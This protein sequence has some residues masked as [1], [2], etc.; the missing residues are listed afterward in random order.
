MDAPPEHRAGFVALAGL[1]NVGKSTLLNRLVGARLSIVTRKAQTTRRRLLGIYSDDRHQAVFVDTPGLL[2]PRYLLQEAMQA[3]AM[4]AL[5]DADQV[6][7]VVDAGYPASVD[8]AVEFRPPA[9]LPYLI[10]LNKVDRVD[11][12]ER[13]ALRAR[14]AAAAS[15]LRS[16]DAGDTP[17]VEVL[18]T[19]ASRGEGVDAL[20]TAI[21][22]R[23]PASPPLYP[24]DELSTAP[25]R[26]FASELVRE[27]C[28]EQLGQELPYS[29]AV[30]VE[31][32]KDRGEDRPVYIE[33][34]IYVER[35]SQKGIVIGDGG[36]RIREIGTSARRKIEAFLERR[37][38][39]EL[40]VKVLPN[41]RKRPGSLRML[42][43]RDLPAER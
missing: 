2:E 40:R 25:V 9:A 39:L 32:F 23:L 4:G 6:V 5:T 34:R 1:T 14:L 30:Q 28:F 31:E 11:S 12:E 10:C 8:A 3:E 13:E 33:A 19:V 16:P 7:Y 42:G 18:D 35:E 41:W 43:Y 29:I 36:R 22:D 27:S 24:Q 20:R 15:E 38:Y 21:L 37:V 17:A 26:Y